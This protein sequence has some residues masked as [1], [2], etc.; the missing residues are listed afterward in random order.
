MRR[1]EDDRIVHAALCEQT[2]CLQA[3]LEEAKRRKQQQEEVQAKKL[4]EAVK[5]Q[6]TMAERDLAKQEQDRADE[7][8]KFQLEIDSL[9]LRM[10]AQTVEQNKELD[11]REK[12][13]ANLL[14]ANMREIQRQLKEQEE[15]AGK[16]LKEAEDKHQRMLKEQAEAAENL[17]TATVAENN[18]QLEEKAVLADKWKSQA[19][20][21]E[22]ETEYLKQQLDTLRREHQEATTQNKRQRRLLD[23]QGE[24]LEKADKRDKQM[25]AMIKEL[26]AELRDEKELLAAKEASAQALIARY[27]C[28]GCQAVPAEMETPVRLH[29]CQDGHGICRNCLMRK[30]L[31]EI[32]NWRGVRLC[33]VVGCAKDI[34]GLES[35]VPYDV[36]NK[37]HEQRKQHDFRVC[38]CCRDEFP[39]AQG[40]TG[41]NCPPDHF[42][43]KG[44]INASMIRQINDVGSNTK[45]MRELW[46]KLPCLGQV[47]A[48]NGEDFVCCPSF[49]DFVK[50]QAML[51]DEG[52]KAL[53]NLQAA[54]GQTDLA[55]VIQELQEESRALRD[56]ALP[57]DE[58]ERKQAVDKIMDEIMVNKCPTCARQYDKFDGCGSLKCPNCAAIWCCVCFDVF[59]SDEDGDMASHEHVRYC[60]VKQL[61]LGEKHTSYHLNPWHY[62][63]VEKARR[64]DAV[65][66]LLRNLRPEIRE[67]VRRGQ[68]W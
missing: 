15:V 66:R 32:D 50:T 30:V 1:E 6:K 49:L 51:E 24:D 60:E 42:L 40:L 11:R 33:C 41:V 12:K 59:P 18:R 61:V 37:Y 7:R 46:G 17:L 36:M 57:V 25:R 13:A 45:Q 39:A 27:I 2:R 28:Q 53:R 31:A 47:L 55:P 35:I 63:A 62:A 20:Q 44:C 38:V 8:L 9:K 3:Q 26:S 4:E 23:D 68:E 48:P 67:K 16:R 22:Q 19:K 52:Q 58:R 34:T 64:R 54:L 10:T 65:N 29:H 21:Q 56:A 43:C 14:Q 5:K